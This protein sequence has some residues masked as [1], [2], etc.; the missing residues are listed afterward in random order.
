VVAVPTGASIAT[1]SLG[2]NS[3]LVTVIRISIRTLILTDT[4]AFA[5]AS[6]ETGLAF[7]HTHNA[8][9]ILELVTV[10]VGPARQWSSFWR[11]LYWNLRRRLAM[12]DPVS[13]KV[14]LAN[15]NCRV[16]GRHYALGVLMANKFDT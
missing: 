3:I 9:G 5:V 11:F 13:D 4:T 10:R 14:V 8:P 16:V 2:T 7:A 1:L 12:G 15:A 6:I